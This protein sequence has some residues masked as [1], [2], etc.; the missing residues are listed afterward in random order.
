MG[1]GLVCSACYSFSV[2]W[3]GEASHELGVQSPDVSAL[4]DV[5]PQS[6]VSP[7]S[8]QSPWIIEV[9]RSVAVVSIPDTFN[10]FPSSM[11]FKQLIVYILM[12]FLLFLLFVFHSLFGLLFLKVLYISSIISV[13]TKADCFLD[14]VSFKNKSPNS[15]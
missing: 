14:I 12:E 10:I 15:E 11:I 3:C 4:P 13:N 9:R 6:S 5:L 1:R 7:A 8:Y 2:W